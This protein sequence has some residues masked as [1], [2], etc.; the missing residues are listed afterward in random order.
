M[1]VFW[2]PRVDGRT[3][4]VGC[5]AVMPDSSHTLLSREYLDAHTCSHSWPSGPA[6]LFF[7]L[8]LTLLGPELPA[9]HYG[10]YSAGFVS[11]RSKQH[12][13]LPPG[14]S[15]NSLGN[16]FTSPHPSPYTPSAWYLRTLG[17]TYFLLLQLSMWGAHL[18]HTYEHVKCMIHHETCVTSSLDQCWFPW[19]PQGLSGPPRRLRRYRDRLV[20]WYA[21]TLRI[22]TVRILRDINGSLCRKEDRWLSI[23][24]FSWTHFQFGHV[25]TRWQSSYQEKSLN[26]TTTW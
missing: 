7:S 22:R 18:R 25:K 14:G 17:F 24:L 19:A 1:L 8:S 2:G 13:R 12:I 10:G 16:R 26:W 5:W 21:S 9:G 11:K 20:L 23:R 15:R 3:V 6:S 4:V